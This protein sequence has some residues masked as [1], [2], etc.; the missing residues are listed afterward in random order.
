[1]NTLQTKN[2]YSEVFELLKQIN[3]NDLKNI[4]INLLETIKENRNK[5]YV[6]EIDLND[7]N[8]SLSKQA[9]SLYMWLYLTYMVDSKEEK[10]KINN[11]L[12][13]N[14][15]EEKDKLK[16][17]KM[18]NKTPNSTKTEQNTQLVVY[19]TNIFKKFINKIKSFFKSKGK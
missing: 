12:Y 4:P 1:M 3:R 7:I 18:F 16:L 19:K 11:I 17:N 2:S 15:I 13:Q 5:E 14:E 10:N 9:I 6:P 8:K